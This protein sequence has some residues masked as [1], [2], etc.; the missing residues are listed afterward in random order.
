MP[1]RHSGTP[2]PLRRRV[3]ALL[4]PLIAL[5]FLLPMMLAPRAEAQVVRG[6]V[7]GW[8]MEEGLP[9]APLQGDTS[10]AG[11]RVWNWIEGDVQRIEAEGWTRV[12]IGPYDFRAER[13]T[14]WVHRRPGAAA[15]GQAVNEIVL[16]LEALGDVDRPTGISSAG[17][18]LLVTAT[19]VGAIALSADAFLPGVPENEALS[20]RGEARAMASLARPRPEAQGVRLD[21][22]EIQKRDPID[23]ARLNMPDPNAPPGDPIPPDT[24][25]PQ[26]A[27][28]GRPDA[29]VYF[30]A[31]EVEYQFAEDES[32]GY[33]VLGGGIVV[34]YVE[35]Q[36]RPGEDQPRRL[37]ISADRAVV[38][39]DPL[40]M[41]DVLQ[42][43][44]KAE[45]V[46]GVYL[47][48]DVAATDGEFTL[49]GPRM[50]YE[51]STNRAVVLEA[52]L[53]TYI[54][55]AQVPLY[56][57]ADE[58]RQVTRREWEADE[59]RIATSEF[60]TPVVSLGATSIRLEE[61]EI[62][63][64]TRNY[65]DVRGA[66]ARAG[67]VPFFFWP[68][69]RGEAERPLIRELTFGSSGRL[70]TSVETE[71]DLFALIGRSPEN[72][73]A[74]A[75]LILDYFSERGPAVGL[76]LDYRTDSGRGNFFGY[77]I[78]DDGTDTLSSG[79]EKQIEDETRGMALFTHI[80]D[81]GDDWKLILEASYLS[82]ETFLDNYFDSLAETRREFQTRAYLLHQRDNAAFEIFANYDLN[83]FVPNEDLLQ[84]QQYLVEK[85]PEAGYY[86]YADALFDG[87]VTWS[88]E[89]RLSRMRLSFPR[90]SP[91][92]IG[93]SRRAFN[94]V[95]TTSFTDALLA[96][97]LRE[98]WVSRIY[99]RHEVAAPM[100]VGI[101][102]VTPFLMGRFAGYDD[103]FSEFQAAT[104]AETEEAW[105][106]G[107]AGLRVFANF[108]RVDNSVES[109]LFDLHRMRHIIEPNLTLWHGES[110]AAGDDYPIYDMDV[111]GVTR[112]SAV[113][114]GLRN[115]WQTQ[116]G[117]EGRWRSVDVFRLDTD[118]VFGSG[119][120]QEQ[121]SIPHFYDYRP[122]YSRVGDHVS[123]NGAWQVSDTFIT[124]GDIIYD[125]NEGH[126][127]RGGVGY[128]LDH[129]DDLY[130]FTEA[131]YFDLS[132]ATLLT[133]GLGYRITPL[134]AVQGTT[135][136]DLDEDEARS[137]SMDLTRTLQQ[138]E[139]R[140][141]VSYNQIRDEASFALSLS[142]RVAGSRWIGGPLRESR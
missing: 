7:S 129:T 46:R 47:E 41:D 114:L 37:T 115:T 94:I 136:Y 60:F 127:A 39:T 135:V 141:G 22:A 70:G 99:T 67:N 17:D 43:Q 121:F 51:L 76:D 4:R 2:T 42:Q 71:W 20:L 66:T 40:T 113:R 28:V 14:A 123:A 138:L 104:G 13:F 16:Y 110:N 107:A 59:V 117:G 105:W 56:L 83:D 35:A 126:M 75:G 6:S 109:R 131:R 48:G 98:D 106:M 93:Q 23:Y 130:S 1:Q 64:Q 142:P 128:R 50:Y 54:E 85:A 11:M 78:Q 55:S 24:L 12:S 21:R 5:A 90:I 3:C 89:Y 133:L 53:S 116:R 125:L 25:S 32:E 49:R 102:K 108:S 103:D 139:L 45:Q 80:E 124:A 91:A 118:L 19:L 68:R 100:Q 81:L 9:L 29:V 33:A 34:E 30:Q 119:E 111:E 88:S 97:G 95:P 101:F 140:F 18:D 26:V 31:G 73:D 132:S 122:E 38:F 57:R 44:L 77:L 10:L 27:A 15:E 61:R 58:I 86:R 36:R 74:D 137:F 52:V 63:G 120:N 62:N 82:D 112:G 87:R 79:R 69:Y 134:Y 8:L 72:I 65:V 92:D 84:S 96:T